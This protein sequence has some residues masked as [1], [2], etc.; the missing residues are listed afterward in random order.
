MW[1][2]WGEA[3]RHKQQAANVQIGTVRQ[4]TCQGAWL[5]QFLQSASHTDLGGKNMFVFINKFLFFF[6]ISHIIHLKYRSKTK[7]GGGRGG[8]SP[9]FTCV[10]FL[11]RQTEREKQEEKKA[12]EKGGD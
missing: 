4:T 9:T 2:E 7:V 3:G 6:V 8:L 5:D 11:K 12:I 1:A 10:L